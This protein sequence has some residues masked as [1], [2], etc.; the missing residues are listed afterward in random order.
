MLAHQDKD[1]QPTG[2]S[3]CY[4]FLA[5]HVRLFTFN[6]F[7]R[8]RETCACFRN[9]ITLTYMCFYPCYFQALI[10]YIS[11]K[12]LLH[13]QINLHCSCWTLQMFHATGLQEE[14][15]SNAQVGLPSC[16]CYCCTSVAHGP[17]P[18]VSLS[19]GTLVGADQISTGSRGTATPI[20][21]FE[22]HRRLRGG[23]R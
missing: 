23:C 3:V 1:V 18:L 9:V 15:I 10:S 12:L 7:C 4:F 19:G 5:R 8:E 11:H 6:S 17:W 21:H 22:H 16:C 20:T 2:L 14:T 13:R